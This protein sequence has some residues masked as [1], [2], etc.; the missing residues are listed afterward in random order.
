[1]DFLTKLDPTVQVALVGVIMAVVTG[2]YGLFQA[3]RKPEDQKDVTAYGPKPYLIKLS[4]EDALRMDKL[5][6]ILDSLSDTIE[7]H[8]QELSTLR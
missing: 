8:R 6:F 4:E 2:A 7:R 3:W 5:T 1:M